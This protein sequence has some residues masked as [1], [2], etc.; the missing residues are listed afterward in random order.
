VS[1]SRGANSAGAHAE[2]VACAHALAGSHAIKWP[3]ATGALLRHGAERGSGD[4]AAVRYLFHDAGCHARHRPSGAASAI[5][6][7]LE[8]ARLDVIGS[9]WMPGIAVNLLTDP[10]RL[11]NATQWLAFEVIGGRTAPARI[12]REVAAHR[13]RLSPQLLGD[14]AALAAM[15]DHQT[16][17]APAGAAWASAAAR[18]LPYG[19][20]QEE[21]A[22]DLG[23][24]QSGAVLIRTSI[25]SGA[26]RTD[27]LANRARRPI[28]AGLPTH[29]AERSSKPYTVFNADEDRVIDAAALTGLDEL[30]SLR[31]RLDLEFGHT[32]T[33][34]TRLTNR[35][36]RLLLTRQTRQ[37]R[38]DLDEGYVDGRRL[39]QVIAAPHS[40]RPF[41]QEAESPFPETAV[42][43]LIDHSGS[44]KGRPILMAALT[45][46]LLVPA[47]ERCAIKCEVLGFTTRDCEGGGPAKAWHDAGAPAHPGRLAALEHIVFKAIDTPWRVARR[48]LGLLLRQDLLKE[49]VDG[50]AILW[51]HQRLSRRPERRKVLLVISDG[52][53]YDTATER[54]NGAGYL[55]RHLR[56]VVDTIEGQSGVEIAAIGIG[57][58]VSRFYS[59]STSITTLDDLAQALIASLGALLTAGDWRDSCGSGQARRRASRNA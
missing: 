45:V 49:N 56:T 37:W 14:L 3:T 25:E 19:Q 41:M 51:A 17:F 31:A 59:R 48:G 22:L 13:V 11:D 36:R 35:L 44:M 29:D 7:A 15:L 40:A 47:L 2:V 16:E 30:A 50:E 52:A 42:T 10:G 4:R 26:L 23:E 34:V 5:F 9:R 1:D 54:A 46:E 20:P 57:H 21:L 18:V 38:F 12:A 24:T 6:D 27:R 39:A 28:E 55:A 58:D 8:Q 43:L 33:A 53:P 32:R